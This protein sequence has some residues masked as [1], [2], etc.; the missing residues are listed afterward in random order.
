MSHRDP[1]LSRRTP[2]DSAY[3]TCERT[4]VSL[5]IYLDRRPTSWVTDILGISPTSV[6]DAGRQVSGS[7]RIARKTGWFLGSEGYV[8]SLDVRDHLDWLSAKLGGCERQLHDLQR[9]EGVSISVNCVWWSKFG[10]GGPTIWPEQM[11]FLSQMGLE[12]TFDFSSYGED[13]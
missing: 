7:R 12:L 11:M 3:Q 5:C 10:Q 1:V 6:V 9:E 8:D 2:V 4:T 13:D